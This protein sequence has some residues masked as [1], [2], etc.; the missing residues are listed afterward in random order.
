MKVRYQANADLNMAVVLAVV[1]REATIDF[2][3]AETARL[4]A[5]PDPKALSV[6]AADGRVLVTHD[7]KTMPRHFEVRH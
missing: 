4:A 1:R 2:H 7:N 3:T 6:A 5:L